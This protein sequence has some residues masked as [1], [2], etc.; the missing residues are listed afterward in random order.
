MYTVVWISGILNY[1]S[2]NMFILVYF[3]VTYVTVLCDRVTYITELSKAMATAPSATLVEDQVLV[4]QHGPPPPS[5][6]YAIRQGQVIPPV[7]HPA[8]APYP[9][10]NSK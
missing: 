4:G 1:V 5:Y 3:A 6:E 2:S 9:H 10:Q 8:V 7:V